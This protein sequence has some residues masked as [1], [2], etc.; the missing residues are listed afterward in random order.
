M[1]PVFVMVHIY[2]YSCACELVIRTRRFVMDKFLKS[3]YIHLDNEL[4]LTKHFEWCQQHIL[5]DSVPELD[6]FEDYRHHRWSGKK[7]DILLLN[8]NTSSI[9][10]V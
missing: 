10:S 5:C 3:K 4:Y 1:I 2:R 9:F 6:L 7:L 8:L